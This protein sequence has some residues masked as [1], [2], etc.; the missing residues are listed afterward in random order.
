M[1]G[2][3]KHFAFLDKLTGQQVARKQ[4]YLTRA[5]ECLPSIAITATR[6]SGEC[7][8]SVLCA[9]LEGNV[10]RSNR[11]LRDGFDLVFNVV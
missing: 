10:R 8:T 1:I 3:P 2:V 6:P 9:C 4:E 11:A 7:V 5:N